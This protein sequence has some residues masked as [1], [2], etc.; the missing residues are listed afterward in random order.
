VFADL[1]DL[2]DARVLQAGDGLGLRYEPPSL[3]RS[4]VVGHEVLDAGEDILCRA[5]ARARTLLAERT[6]EAWG[7]AD[8]GQDF[9]D[10]FEQI[11]TIHETKRR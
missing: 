10:V 8:V 3:G 7:I 5:T 4:R 6:A 11:R 9:V 2:D 1:E